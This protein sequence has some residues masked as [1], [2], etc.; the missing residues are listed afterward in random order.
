MALG[1]HVRCII[2]KAY[3]LLLLELA[4]AVYDPFAQ[5]GLDHEY[6][7][8]FFVGII[9]SVDSHVLGCRQLGLLAV[10]QSRQLLLQR[11]PI[12]LHVLQVHCI[13]VT[14]LQLGS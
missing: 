2:F 5:E 7:V 11:E 14:F 13:D 4:L 8:T 3:L 10:C 6:W 12:S 1:V 9:D